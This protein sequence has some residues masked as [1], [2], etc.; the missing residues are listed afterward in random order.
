MAQL[1]KIISPLEKVFFDSAD[2]FDSFSAFSMM[3]NEKSRFSFCFPPGRGSV[4]GF[5]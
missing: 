5:P 4:C 3:K 1:I 2:N